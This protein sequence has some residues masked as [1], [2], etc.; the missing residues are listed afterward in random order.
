M[1][2]IFVLSLALATDA[3]AV[4]LVSGIK[5][6]SSRQIFRLSFHFGLFQFILSLLG[7]TLLLMVERY[8]SAFDHWIAFILLG[9]IGLKMI[10]NGIKSETE[11]EI[12]QYDATRGLTL[13]GLSLA[14]SIDA[15]AAGISIPTIT[16]HYFISTILIGIIAGLGTFLAMKLSG[17]VPIQFA[18]RSEIIGGIVLIGIGFKIVLDHLNINDII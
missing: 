12:R 10:H 1:I 11:N 16:S 18:K 9:L 14:V 3:F 7:A 2:E 13:I 17:L 6:K 4:G 8:V 5:Y 15:L